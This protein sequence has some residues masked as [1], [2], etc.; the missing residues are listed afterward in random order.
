[1]TRDPSLRSSSAKPGRGTPAGLRSG[2]PG[3][4]T[5][6]KS[7]VSCSASGLRARSRQRAQLLG[8]GLHHVLSRALR[9]VGFSPAELAGIERDNALAVLPRYRDAVTPRE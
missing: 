6:L 4:G 7:P 9:G 3:A 1:M 2:L 5:R 8:D